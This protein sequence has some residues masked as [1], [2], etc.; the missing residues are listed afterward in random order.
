M[1]RRIAACTGLSHS[2]RRSSVYSGRQSLAPVMHAPTRDSRPLKTALFQQAAARNV[3][4]FCRNNR[5]PIVIHEKF[6]TGSATTKDFQGL[7]K[8]LIGSFIDEGYPWNRKFED[9]C[10]QV[11]KDL[12]YPGLEGIS[13]TTLGSLGSGSTWM[14]L[15]GML[16]WLVELCKVSSVHRRQEMG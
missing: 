11:L 12:R 13:K 1:E 8:W 2:V 6:W 7:V 10:V 3:E 5:C 4:S 14:V 15:V 16:N 9:D